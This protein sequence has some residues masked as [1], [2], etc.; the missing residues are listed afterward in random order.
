MKK[1]NFL[2]KKKTLVCKAKN[3]HTFTLYDIGVSRKKKSV[4]M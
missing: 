1:S 3:I 2:R 4:F